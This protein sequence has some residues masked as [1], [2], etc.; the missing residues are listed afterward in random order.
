M[1]VLSKQGA[2]LSCSSCCLS[3][4]TEKPQTSSPMFAVTKFANIKLEFGHDCQSY[5]TSKRLAQLPKRACWP[6]KGCLQSH[7]SML[8]ASNRESGLVCAG[9]GCAQ[10]ATCAQRLL[11]H[12]L[13]T[14][15][16]G[17]VARTLQGVDMFSQTQLAGILG[18]SHHP[19]HTLPQSSDAQTQ[20]HEQHSM[21]FECV[22]SC[23]CI[24]LH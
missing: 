24:G 2:S 20:V 14:E 17:V 11:E 6:L 10:V 21:L 23:R 18:H 13:L 16:Q 4:V 22:A 3:G 12:S 5:T 1:G 19:P 15:L 8:A 7:S 9:K